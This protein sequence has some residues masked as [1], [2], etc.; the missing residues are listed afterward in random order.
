LR[1]FH[2]VNQLQQRVGTRIRLAD[3]HD[4]ILSAA[5]KARRE[6]FFADGELSPYLE[7]F[8]LTLPLA[9]HM[10]E[11][12]HRNVTIVTSEAFHGATRMFLPIISTR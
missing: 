8:T 6:I 11:E 3:W 12:G 5:L 4:A 1:A 7:T 10:N 9:T 2:V